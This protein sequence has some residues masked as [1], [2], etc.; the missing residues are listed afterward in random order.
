MG[1]QKQHDKERDRETD[2]FAVSSL[3]FAAIRTHIA[4]VAAVEVTTSV[5]VLVIAI[6]VT[7]PIFLS[8]LALDLFDTFVAFVHEL[9]IQ[10]LA[11]F[12]IL[13]VVPSV[14]HRRKSRKS[15]PG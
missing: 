14:D 13:V 4:T 9:A 3:H 12:A 1:W 11:V 5:V 2:L 8:A 15:L 10:A 6:F 7:L